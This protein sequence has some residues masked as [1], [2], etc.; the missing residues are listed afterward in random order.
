MW[1]EQATPQQHSDFASLVKNGQ[2]EFVLGGWVMP[3]RDDRDITMA[4]P[5]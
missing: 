2:I 5:S 4:D 3:V 1:W